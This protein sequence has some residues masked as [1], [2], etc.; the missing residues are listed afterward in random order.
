[1]KTRVTIKLLEYVRKR[2][3]NLETAFSMFMQ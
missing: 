2:I 1:M 3:E